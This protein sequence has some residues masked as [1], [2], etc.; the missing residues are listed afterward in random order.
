MVIV[1]LLAV[2]VG[3]LAQATTGIGFTLVVVPAC[4]LLLDP[5]DVLGTVARLGLLVDLAVLYQGR[6]SLDLRHVGGYALPAAL[7]VPAALAASAAVPER[8]LVGVAAAAT[9]AGGVLLLRQPA[10]AGAGRPVA[11]G[12]ASG[13]LGVTVGMP[14]PPVAIDSARRGLTPEATRA[15]L[16]AFFAVLDLA[17]AVAHPSAV[18]G[19]LTALLAAAAAA[20]LVAGHRVAR[21]ADAAD[22]R[23]ALAVLVVAGAAAALARLVL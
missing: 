21:R 23:N 13:F 5:S 22:L 7:A 9:M 10:V 6:R 11:A 1:L 17:A 12:F 3:S 4:A 8:G 20:G 2:A 18:G 15:S 16:A 14:G 19:G